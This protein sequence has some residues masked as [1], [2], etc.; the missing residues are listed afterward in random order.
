MF[1]VVTSGECASGRLK[2]KQ[3]GSA[4]ICPSTFVS[5]NVCCEGQNGG[6]VPR[7]DMHRSHVVKLLLGEGGGRQ[8]P[9][10]TKIQEDDA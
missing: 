3:T 6:S 8:N 1:F 7:P 10:V 5:S 4:N 9:L 2:Q